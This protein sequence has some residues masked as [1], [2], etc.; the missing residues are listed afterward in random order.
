M[1][2]T[3]DMSQTPEAGEEVMIVTQ[4][5]VSGDC[6]HMLAWLQWRADKDDASVRS[7]MWQSTADGE[8]IEAPFE[9]YGWTVFEPAL[10]RGER[11][12]ETGE[13]KF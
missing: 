13:V 1:P 4:D 2:W 5:T 10:D 3:Y 6:S 9:I 11:D 7:L 12:L 8:W